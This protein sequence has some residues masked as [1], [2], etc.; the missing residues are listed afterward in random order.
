MHYEQRMKQWG[1]SMPITV[2]SILRNAYTRT[3]SG[4]KHALFRVVQCLLL[5]SDFYQILLYPQ[6]VV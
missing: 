4:R 6:V 2:E 1:K 5:L 3:S